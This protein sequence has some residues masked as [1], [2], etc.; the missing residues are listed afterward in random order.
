MLVFSVFLKL[1]FRTN[2]YKWTKA[3]HRLLTILKTPEWNKTVVKI[4]ST[5]CNPI[6][7]LVYPLKI[8]HLVLHDAYYITASRIGN[9]CVFGVG[10]DSSHFILFQPASLKHNRKPSLWFGT[11]QYSLLKF[12]HVSPHQAQHSRWLSVQFLELNWAS[13]TSDIVIGRL[14]CRHRTTA[15]PHRDMRCGFAHQCIPPTCP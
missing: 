6:F 13:E 12:T 3:L 10:M 1:A 2:Q 11:W 4:V 5:S 14:C 15:A 9:T 7:F 8:D